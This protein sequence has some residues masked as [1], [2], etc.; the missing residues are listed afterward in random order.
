[1]KQA[2]T[3]SFVLLVAC[4]GACG[5]GRQ[6]AWESTTTPAA[7]AA[8]KPPH[9]KIDAESDVDVD[10]G[11][12]AGQSRQEQLAEAERWWAKRQSRPALEKAIA[13]WDIL[14]DADDVPAPL[15]AQLAR[16]YYLYADNFLRLAGEEQPMLAAFEQ[17]VRCGE[18]A[19]MAASAAFAQ[20]MREGARVEEA[21]ALIP[22]TGLPAVYWYATNLGKFALAKGFATTLFYKDRIASV[23][24]WV[25]NT[26]ERFFYGAPHRYF[27]AFY[28]K[29]PA[30]AGGDLAKSK[31][32]FERALQLSPEYLGTKV[33]YAEFYAVKADDRQLFTRLLQNVQAADANALPELVPEQR[34]EQ[35]KAQHLLGKID[36]LF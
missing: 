28:A 2:T 3:V 17:G 20:K 5:P 31:E 12:T 27:G 4:G 33:V 26:D 29:A 36:E 16:A 35:E 32:H 22:A 11:A 1:M 34:L 24:Q 8:A 19:M 15:L 23:M 14:S 30:F 13:I 18:R 21:V 6:A 10:T 9:A 7:K 25:L